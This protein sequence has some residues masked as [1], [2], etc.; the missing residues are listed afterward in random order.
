M[1]VLKLRHLFLKGGDSIF[2]A[3]LM[4][5]YHARYTVDSQHIALHLR[6]NINQFKNCFKLIKK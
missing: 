3:T 1:N 2:I 6:K 5:W 4:V